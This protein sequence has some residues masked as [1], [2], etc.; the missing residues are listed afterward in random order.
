MTRKS[1]ID[2]LIVELSKG[3]ERTVSQL[4]RKTGLRNVSA[5]VNTLRKGGY[6]IKTVPYTNGDGQAYRMNNITR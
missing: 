6:R 5:A 3:R 2:K 1:G 4:S